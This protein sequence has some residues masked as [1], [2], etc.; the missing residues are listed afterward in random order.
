VARVGS[1]LMFR[2]DSVPEE[3]GAGYFP[4]AGD[5]VR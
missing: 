2:R 1:G 4:F 5:F 3:G